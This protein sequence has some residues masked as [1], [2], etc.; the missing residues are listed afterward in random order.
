[1]TFLKDG[2]GKTAHQVLDISKTDGTGVLSITCNEL[3]GHATVTGPN[4][5]DIHLVTPQIEG[6][7]IVTAGEDK[8]DC[9]FAGQSVT[10][11]NTGCNFTLTP[12]GTLHIISEFASAPNTCKH[13]EKPIHFANTNLNCKVEIGE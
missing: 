8:M 6:G 9:T 4:P 11:N 3:T 12:D 13:G 1:M 2:T 7:G 5:A 10:I